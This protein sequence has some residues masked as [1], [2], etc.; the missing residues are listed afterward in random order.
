[1]DTSAIRLRMDFDQF[2]V[3]DT[4]AIPETPAPVPGVTRRMLERDGGE[5]ARATSIVRYAAGRSFPRH[6]HD[7]GEEIFVL[8]GT[9]ADEHGTYPAGTYL[10]NPP[11]S[12]HE[13]RTDDGCE[14]FV[15]L[16]HLDADD[17]QRVVIDT[18]AG[19]WQPGAFPGLM[20][21]LLASYDT[22]RTVLVRWDPGTHIPPHTH[23]SVEETLVL[24]GE[25]QDDAHRYPAGTWF[26]APR[27]STHAPFSDNGA[28]ILIKVGHVRLP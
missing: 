11:G 4:R 8:S 13:P 7:L 10:R 6:T 2:E 18:R 3:A 20:N 1:M 23:G 12:S 21:Q 22:E 28:L 5:V 15:K 17:H 14:L 19:H 26:R 24:E 27:G 25:I 16:R 9:F